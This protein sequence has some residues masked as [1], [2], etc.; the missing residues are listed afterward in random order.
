MCI[1]LDAV[2]E[3]LYARN[4][5][6]VVIEDHRDVTAIGYRFEEAH[7]GDDRRRR[8]WGPTRVRGIGGR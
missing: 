3:R 5:A 4:T 8:K 2:A 1:A 6:A 7:D